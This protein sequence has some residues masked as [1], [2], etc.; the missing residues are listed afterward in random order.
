[1]TNQSTRQSFQMLQTNLYQLQFKKVSKL[2]QKRAQYEYRII[3]SIQHILR[4]RPDIVIRRTDKSKVFY[5][6]KAT[7]F[8]QKAA[9]YMLKTEA[10]QEITSGQCPLFNIFNTVQH[11]LHYLMRTRSLT[12]KQCNR[13]SPKL[14][15]LELGHYHGLPKPHKVKT[16]SFI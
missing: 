10:Y 13:I 6:G 4:H 16:H 8:I 9:E 5:I 14:N 3:Q 7:D 12:T 11:L 15:N 2:Q 1:M